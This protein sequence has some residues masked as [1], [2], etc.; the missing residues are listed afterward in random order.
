M[1]VLISCS[2][3]DVLTTFVSNQVNVMN[4]SI[5]P[6]G[7][8]VTPTGRIPYS[9]LMHQVSGLIK[10]EAVNPEFD[11][12][13]LAYRL[14]VNKSTLNKHLKALCGET[15]S[16]ML[17]RHRLQLAA[18][19]LKQP[20]LN[21]R[22]VAR[23]SGFYH[24]TVFSKNFQQEF[25]CSPKVY[26]ER[27][28]TPTLIEDALVWRTC[29]QSQNWNCLMQQIRGNKWI[30]NFFK[31][32]LMNLS[33]GRFTEQELS[34]SLCITTVA[35]QRMT[36]TYF[37]VS[38]QRLILCARLFY[39]LELSNRRA[40]FSDEIARKAGFTSVRYLN[41]VYQRMFN[42]TVTTN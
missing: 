28:C 16:A 17:L 40:A 6:L 33:E 22:D 31:E 23:Q 30:C 14:G 32:L 7:T 24:Q 35:L 2:G 41:L 15:A 1:Q 19:L 38:P 26:R 10:Q 5:Y 36:K 11:V 27:E 21:M 25:G 34:V 4:V 13:Q 37:A 20:E 9:G 39:A 29:Y 42:E 18:Q 12:V 3:G 8:A